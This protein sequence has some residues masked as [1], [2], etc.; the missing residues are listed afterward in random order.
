MCLEH[1]PGTI[2]TWSSRLCPSNFVLVD[3][4]ALGRG[5]AN[6]TKF[7]SPTVVLPV[8]FISIFSLIIGLILIFYFLSYEENMKVKKNEKKNNFLS[9]FWTH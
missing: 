3:F 8:I 6:V 2:A 1:I 7:F 5:P 4:V 9:L